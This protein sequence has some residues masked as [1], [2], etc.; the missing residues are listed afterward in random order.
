[1][2]FVIFSQKIQINHLEYASAHAK[3]ERIKLII[4]LKSPI[5]APADLIILELPPGSM[6]P[7]VYNNLP[8]IA[9]N[10]KIAE[11]TGYLRAPTIIKRV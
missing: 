6:Y 3:M 1:M 11:N 10:P 2:N 5:V 4:I 9:T 7:I 8:V